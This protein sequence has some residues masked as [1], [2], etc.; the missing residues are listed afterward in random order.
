MRLSWTSGI[1]RGY[2]IF[3]LGNVKGDMCPRTALKEQWTNGQHS[4]RTLI[5]VVAKLHINC[6]L[7]PRH[8]LDTCMFSRIDVLLL[9]KC[10]R[11]S[12]PS[13]TMWGIVKTNLAGTSPI[14]APDFTHCTFA[15]PMRSKSAM[16]PSPSRQ[17][18]VWSR[19]KI[20]SFQL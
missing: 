18:H 2:S 6:C 4:L 13:T 9:S 17:H 3:I 11:N 15:N 7:S 1:W 8:R 19:L 20:I 10:K 12:F 14:S 16:V 5:L